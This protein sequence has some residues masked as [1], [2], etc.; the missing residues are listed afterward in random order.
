[1]SV[2]LHPAG[3]PLHRFSARL[4]PAHCQLHCVGGPLYRVRPLLHP[5][6]CSPLPAMLSLYSVSRM[7]YSVSRVLCRSVGCCSSSVAYSSPS[8]ACSSR[9]IVHSSVPEIHWTRSGTRPHS[10]LARLT[11]HPARSSPRVGMSARYGFHFSRC[12][13]WTWHEI[14]NGR[15]YREE[16][17]VSLERF[18]FYQPR[19]GAPVTRRINEKGGEQD[20]QEDP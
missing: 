2:T 5:A 13:C 11:E 15:F 17:G 20:E 18:Q 19:F 4:H 6:K 7:L 12:D 9:P 16:T 14:S 1:M 8:V 10:Q 3:Y